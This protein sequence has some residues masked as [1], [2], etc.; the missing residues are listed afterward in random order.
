MTPQ[1][2]AELDARVATILANE[3]KNGAPLDKSKEDAIMMAVAQQV[4]L[5]Q[6]PGRPEEKSPKPVRRQQAKLK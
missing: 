3:A 4:P 1:Q 5:Y 2:R 6:E